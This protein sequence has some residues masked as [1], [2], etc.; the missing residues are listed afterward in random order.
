[1]DYTTGPTLIKPTGTTPVTVLRPEFEWEAIDSTSS[2]ELLVENTTVSPATTVN[3]ETNIPHV[4]GATSI[5]YTHP[6]INLPAGT[7]RWTVRAT[8]LTNIQTAFT[9][10]RT[11]TVPAPT[12]TNPTAA[13]NS[14]NPVTTNVPEFRWTGVSQFVKYEIIVF[15]VDRNRVEFDNLNVTG[16]SYTQRALDG[17][18]LPLSDG[19][20]T[21]KVRGVD[22][23]GN[24]S[25]YSTTVAFTIK[26]TLG[27]GPQNLNQT[28]NGTTGARTFTWSAVTNAAKYEVIVKRI[29]TS[30]Q[31]IVINGTTTTNATSFTSSIALSSGTYR[32]WVRG[33]SSNNVPGPWSQPSE[34]FVQN[35][36]SPAPEDQNS[37]DGLLTDETTDS[38]VIVGQPVFVARSIIESDFSQISVHPAGMT[39]QVSPERLQELRAEQVAKSNSVSTEQEIGID[40]MMQ[41]LA[42]GNW[43]SDLV[44]DGQIL[45]AVT[46]AV[47]GADIAPVSAVSAGDSGSG[48][49]GSGSLGA[50]G[51]VTGLVA[52]AFGGRFRRTIRRNE[53]LMND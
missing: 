14:A 19:N 48:S 33:I 7:F 40:E 36:S 46:S 21:V 45:T 18:A 13:N 37:M 20:Y 30:G 39:V 44:A 11:F 24:K 38:A 2:Y 5:K 6:T 31:P 10:A 23:A 29:T 22:A 35:L 51:I 50:A 52:A 42:G 34:F 3:R 15:S 1:M 9:T 4:N 49:S 28:F 41:E 43:S 53:E 47:S 17:S 27:Q 25:P 32:W 12:I 26:A 8:S 16:T